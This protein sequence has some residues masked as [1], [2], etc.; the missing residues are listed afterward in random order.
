MNVIPVSCR[1]PNT[2]SYFIKPT[3]FRGEKSDEKKAPS[4]AFIPPEDPP[5]TPIMPPRLRPAGQHSTVKTSPVTPPQVSKKHHIAFGMAK[6]EEEALG[7]INDQKQ[8]IIDARNAVNKII[9]AIKDDKGTDSAE[10]KTLEFI[11][12]LKDSEE[13]AKR[14]VLWQEE[15]GSNSMLT[16]AVSKEKD[17]IAEA[18]IDLAGGLDEKTQREFVSMGINVG[19]ANQYVFLN[20]VASIE[21][22]V[23]FLDMVNRVNPRLLL[24]FDISPNVIDTDEFTELAARVATNPDL[25]TKET[26]EFLNKCRLQELAKIVDPNAD[27]IIANKQAKQ[28]EAGTRTRAKTEAERALYAEDVAGTVSEIESYGD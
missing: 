5:P 9:A 4:Q 24:K 21:A 15:D 23:K 6:L 7:K 12:N 17:K 11:K 16:L 26:V 14:V 19:N 2:Y 3:P 13:V 10:A 28:T 25:S 1:K 27:K 20:A 8:V 18:I 22:A